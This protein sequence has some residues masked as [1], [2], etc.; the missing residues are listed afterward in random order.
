MGDKSPKNKE[1]NLKQKDSIK[2]KAIQKAQF[3]KNALTAA[4]GKSVK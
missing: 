1:K 2:A 4:A 3:D